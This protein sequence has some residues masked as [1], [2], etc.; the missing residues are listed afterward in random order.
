MANEMTI[1][2]L[3]EGFGKQPRTFQLAWRSAGNDNYAKDREATPEEVARITSYYAK[4]KGRAPKERPAPQPSPATPP[5]P[6]PATPPAAAKTPAVAKRTAVPASVRRRVGLWLLIA[7]PAVASFDNMAH[8]AAGIASGVGVYSLTTTV[9]FACSAAIF[10][11]S[12]IRTPQAKAIVALLVAYEG[13][14]NAVKVYGGLTG[15]GASGCPTR[16]LGLITDMFGTG[17][18]PTALFVSGFV[19]ALLCAVQYSAIFE[20]QKN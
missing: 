17:T 19:A 9:V 2:Q 13:L 5:Q 3:R 1:E 8:I 12:G 10:L 20:L 14:C 7:A 15:F 18:Y 11:L 16:F 6:S 4:G